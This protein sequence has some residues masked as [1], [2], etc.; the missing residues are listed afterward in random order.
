MAGMTQVPP[1]AT[2]DHLTVLLRRAG[3]FERGAVIEVAVET[4]RDTLI[5]RI[6]RLR[7]TYDPQGDAGPSHVFFKT[8][9]ERVDGLL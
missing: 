7:L 3:V 5:S 6:A 1:Q 8:S 4:S 9:H 2:P